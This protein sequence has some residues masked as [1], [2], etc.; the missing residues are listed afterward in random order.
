[1]T[2]PCFTREKLAARLAEL[3]KYLDRAVV[4]LSFAWQPGRLADLRPDGWRPCPPG[5]R[6]GE[7]DEWAVFRTAAEPPAEWA[8]LPVVARIRLAQEEGGEAL[9]YLDGRPYQGLDRHHPVIP[10]SE[11]ARPG[12]RWEIVLEAYTLTSWP[13]VFTLEEA[14]LAVPDET[15]LGFYHD[16][17]AALETVC[18]LPAEKPARLDLLAALNEACRRIDWHEAPGEAFRASLREAAAVLRE[19]LAAIPPEEAPTITAVGHA[20]L[21]VAWL[22]PL[23]QT[24]A[25]AARTFA[26]VL[27]LMERY[28]EF[29]FAQSQPQL[30]AFVE[31]DHPSLFAEIQARVGEGR[32]EPLG[33]MWVEADTNLSGGESLI[34]QFLLGRR[35][36]RRAFGHPGTPVLW[37]PDSFGYSAALPQIAAGCGLRYFVTTKLSWNEYNR[38]PYDSFRWR[39]LDGTELLAHCLRTP[40]EWGPAAENRINT[41]SGR[42]TAAEIDEAWRTYR[43]KSVHR[44]L[45]MAFGY[46]DGGGGPTAEMIEYGRRLRAMPGLPGLA[47]GKVS[48]FFVRLEEK[49]ERLPV[50]WGELYLEYHRGTYTSQ[51]RTK[52]A[53]RKSECLYHEAEFLASLA[54]LW[55]AEYPREELEEGWRLI[56]TNQFH[57]ILP[58]SSIGAVY[59]ESGRQYERVEALGRKVRGDALAALIAG[60]AM[61]DDGIVVFNPASWERRDPVEAAVP[62]SFAGRRLLDPSGREAPYQIVEKTGDE[63]RLVFAARGVPAYGYEVYSFAPGLPAAG[64]PEGESGASLREG[65]AGG[66]ILENRFFRAEI[67][68]AGRLRSLWDKKAGREAI[69]AGAAGNELQLFEDKPLNF[70]AWDINLFYQEKKRILADPAELRILEHGPIRAVL[71]VRRSF[72]RS[73]LVQR[74]VAYAN[75][76]RLDFRTEIDWRERHTLLKAAF[77]VAIHAMNAAYEIQFGSLERPTHANTSWDLARFEVPAQKWADLSE[78]GYG[79]SLLNDGKYGYDVR[80]NVLRLSL[81]RSPTYPDP[82]AD[83]GRHEFTY[84]LYPHRGGWRRGTVR[85]AY[86]LNLPLRAVFAPAHSGARPARFGLLCADARHVVVETVKKAEEAPGLIVR[87]YEAHGRRGPVTLSFGPPLRA[88]YECNLVEEEERAI[89]HEENELRFRIGP[90][91]IRTFRVEL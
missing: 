60:I 42:L 49:A 34:R 11:A 10:L 77:P 19:G 88:A 7:R 78:D 35:Y 37:L 51:A 85:R 14:V 61:P 84:S 22:W 25:K 69:A 86:E 28:P 5:T 1:M 47:W 64:P 39:G 8:G 45:L 73:S 43:Q 80:G 52:R 79:V 81:L 65:E 82:E 67:D 89:P 18:H 13:G 24:R 74:I 76:A 71:E 91:Q 3:E 62:A 27:R 59:E 21:D 66:F 31:E 16:F 72:R 38:F 41:Y 26:T 68:P 29:R 57:D 20:H 70:D 30:Y 17:R 4:P 23:S 2:D 55:G 15:A 48:D 75:L 63:V 50:W 53:N 33:G 90:Y 12:D 87:L 44:E 32:W 9:V 58:G 83:Q 54:H 46:G 56:L 36:F 6:W 40:A